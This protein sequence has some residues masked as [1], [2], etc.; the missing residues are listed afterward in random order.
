MNGEPFLRVPATN[1]PEELA[2]FVASSKTCPK[3]GLHNPYKNVERYLMLGRV[4]ARAAQTL[5]DPAVADFFARLIQRVTPKSY[6]QA[7]S[8]VRRRQ[9]RRR[10]RGS[11]AQA[12]GIVCV[13]SLHELGRRGVSARRACRHPRLLSLIRLSH[14]TLA[15]CPSHG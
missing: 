10:L 7:M 1:A 9:R 3:T 6:A 8:E 2:A 4:S 12:G 15:A 11:A 13:P 5:R 14:A